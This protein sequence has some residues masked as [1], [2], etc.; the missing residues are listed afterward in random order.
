MEV[1]IALRQREKLGKLT[2]PHHTMYRNY[3]EYELVLER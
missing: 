2:R 1:A 3:K